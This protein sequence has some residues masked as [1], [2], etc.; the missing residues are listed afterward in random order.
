MPRSAAIAAAFLT[1]A[2]LSACGETAAPSSEPD[3]TPT[4]SSAAP[5]ETPSETTR[6]GGGGDCDTLLS[7]DGRSYRG[8]GDVE[9]DLVEP[10]GTGVAAPCNSADGSDG[11]GGEREV[12]RIQGID[13]AA[14]VGT[15]DR[16]GD[17]LWFVPAGK[18]I[19][20]KLPPEV[21]RLLNGR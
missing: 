15:P 5:A 21:K 9:L 2:L 3:P 12:W 18:G 16:G 17:V 1:G 6:G 10:L 4:P 19:A 7:Y 8:I 13:P 20:G 14:A 11:A